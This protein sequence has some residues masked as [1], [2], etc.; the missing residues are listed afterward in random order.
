[1]VCFYFDIIPS[2]FL[3]KGV[4]HDDMEDH[5]SESKELIAHKTCPLC[6]YVS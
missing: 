5:S 6:G 4:F 2:K 3:N 1:M